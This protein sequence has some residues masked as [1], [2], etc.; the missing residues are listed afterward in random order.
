MVFFPERTRWPP[1]LDWLIDLETFSGRAAAASLG[2]SRDG[3][4]W[5][6]A[7]GP[8]GPSTVVALPDSS[9]VVTVFFY[10]LAEADSTDEPLWDCFLRY[11]EAGTRAWGAPFPRGGGGS[12]RMGAFLRDRRGN[13]PGRRRGHS[14]VLHTAGRAGIRIGTSDSFADH[15]SPTC[16]QQR[17]GRVEVILRVSGVLWS[18]PLFALELLRLRS[19]SVSRA[20]QVEAFVFRIVHPD[21]SVDPLHRERGQFGGQ[22]GDHLTDPLHQGGS[23]NHGRSCLAP[24]G[25]AGRDR[26]SR[27]R[28]VGS[29]IEVF[30]VSQVHVV[31]MTCPVAVHHL[32]GSP[33]QQPRPVPGATGEG[34][35]RRDGSSRTSP[36]GKEHGRGP[37]SITCFRH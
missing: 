31:G 21:G 7:G 16:E 29:E 33:V 13:R 8:T 5:R 26:D 22:A 19:D 20:L 9:G 11:E 12:R 4:P 30:R 28:K 34:P 6:F 25:R 27:D 14:A 35:G 32:G 36:A 17:V 37:W 15:L 23:G 1:A 3:F 18:G 10:T 2:W 24:T